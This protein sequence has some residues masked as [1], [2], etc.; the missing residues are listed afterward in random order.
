MIIHAMLTVILILLLVVST[1]LYFMLKYNSNFLKQ[2][3]NIK[4]LQLETLSPGEEAPLFRVHDT[5]GNKVVAKKLFYNKNT[6]LLFIN[7]SCPTCKTIVEN[8]YSI[9]KH[10]DLNILVINND[11]LFDD[12]KVKAL[13]P[14]SVTYIRASHIP[15]TYFI[16]STPTVILVEKGLIKMINQV[17]NSNVLLNMLITEKIKLKSIS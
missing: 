8:L 16:Q 6:L 5:S 10:Y 17:T 7:S 13:L 15:M 12:N 14:K 2:I 9:D 11:E 3:Q 1:I 4:G